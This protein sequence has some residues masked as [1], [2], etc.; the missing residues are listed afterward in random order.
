MQ[1]YGAVSTVYNFGHLA[2]YGTPQQVAAGEFSG[3]GAF[4]QAESRSVWESRVAYADYAIKEAIRQSVAG[5]TLLQQAMA[6]VVQA[7]TTMTYAKSNDLWTNK[8]EEAIAER[9]QKARALFDQAQAQAL[10]FG[11][12]PFRVP[13]PVWQSYAAKLPAGS[14]GTF[15]PGVI[16]PPTPAIPAPA[17]GG[18]GAP[19]PRV[20]VVAQAGIGT[21]G[22]VL[23]GL[24]LWWL[25]RR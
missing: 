11:E 16:P 13:F 5:G 6:Q 15:S 10:A 20:P 9:L 21:G 24:G 22:L 1:H 19:A 7:K 18:G 14:P 23:I 8:Q 12:R 2:A 4:G 3:Y 25:F 17:P